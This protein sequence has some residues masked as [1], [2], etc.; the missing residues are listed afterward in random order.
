M[1]FNENFRWTKSQSASVI[2]FKSAHTVRLRTVMIN[3]SAGLR[4]A[5][6]RWP[7]EKT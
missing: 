6:E 5:Q 3:S 1:K 7:L 4:A 2:N